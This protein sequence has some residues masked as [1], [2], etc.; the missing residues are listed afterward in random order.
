[1]TRTGPQDFVA[2][3]PSRPR[4]DPRIRQRRVEVRRH[5]GR[6]RLRFLL[7]SL[8]VVGAV[9]GAVAATRSPLMDVDRVELRGASRT[10]QSEVV[11]VTDLHRRP[12][13][14]NV[15]TAG[16]A[17]RVEGLPWVRRARAERRWPGTLRIHVTERVPVAAMAGEN[18]AWALVDD[19]GRVLLMGPDRPPDIPVVVTPG[20]GPKPVGAAMAVGARVPAGAEEA[21]RVAAALPGPL[22][23]RVAE[24]VGIGSSHIE[25]RLRPAGLVCLGSPDGLE[26]KLTA[27]WTVLERAAGSGFAV[28]DVRVPETPV[29]TRR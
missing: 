7:G 29:L 19:T 24:V 11:A 1:M 28:L 5:E 21:L 25:L 2:T 16:L 10:A 27:A 18:G 12:L 15:D 3:S 9:G 4:M 22:R 23:A 26:A 8:A 6:R 14:V 20:T 17:R 13:M